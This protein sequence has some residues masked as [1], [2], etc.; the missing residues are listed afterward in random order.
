[1]IF[2]GRNCIDRKKAADLGMTLFGIGKA[3]VKHAE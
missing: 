2:D 1:M 3:E